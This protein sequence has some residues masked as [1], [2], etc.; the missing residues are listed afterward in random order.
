MKDRRNRTRWLSILLVC[1]VAGRTA[2][3]LVDSDK[4]P[5]EAAAWDLTRADLWRDAYDRLIVEVRTRGAVDPEALRA[6]FLGASVSGTHEREN[7]LWMIE[8]GR[9]YRRSAFAPG[10]A[11]DEVCAAPA[12][13]VS[14]R[15]ICIVPDVMSLKAGGWLMET[16]SRD[17]D[18]VDR[19]PNTGAMAFDRR[20]TARW[21]PR[22]QIASVDLSE[23]YKNAPVS[24]MA[25]FDTDLKG[26]LWQRLTNTP[27]L[28]L[29]F[30]GTSAAPVRI[31]LREPPQAGFAD[32]V[33]TGAWTSGNW[34]R[35]EGETADI[36]YTVRAAR[37]EA[38]EW[39]IDAQWASSQDRCIELAVA[40]LL[41]GAGWRWRDEG[42]R[43]I[44]L[45][46]TS[47]VT[48]LVA[49]AAGTCAAHAVCPFGVVSRGGTAWLLQANVEEPRVVRLSAEALGEHRALVLTFPLALTSATSNFVRRATVSCRLRPVPASA[50]NVFWAAAAEAMPMAAAT[51]T[52]VDREAF[53][54]LSQWPV[55]RGY[56]RL[57]LASGAVV[58]RQDFETLLGFCADISGP[59]GEAAL[60]TQLGG[61]RDPS[62]GLSLRPAQSGGDAAVD[63]NLDP[64]LRVT[65]EQP[66]SPAML[67]WREIGRL[68]QRP[69]T[70]GIIMDLPDLSR[71][72][73]NPSAIG[74][75]DYPCV[76]GEQNPRA[77]LT[78]GAGVFEFLQLAG[79]KI[80][81]QGKRLAVRISGAP[82]ASVLLL[83]DAVILAPSPAKWTVDD[84]ERTARAVRAMAGRR[85]VFVEP[86][87]W[88]AAEETDGPANYV[89]WGFAPYGGV[90][91][92]VA[93]LA[94]LLR[95][96]A[97]S[98]WNL[99][100]S[101]IWPSGDVEARVF[102]ETND[103]YHLALYNGSHRDATATRPESAGRNM[104]WVNPLTGACEYD[105][106]G[107]EIELPAGETTLWDIMPRERAA[108]EIAFLR[109]AAK[110]MA[111]APKIIQNIESW[112]RENEWGVDAR[113]VLPPAIGRPGVNHLRLRIRNGGS[114]PLRVYDVR[115]I[116]KVFWDA[117]VK[118]TVPPLSTTDVICSLDGEGMAEDGWIEVQWKLERGAANVLE[119]ARHLRLTLTE[120]VVVR[121]ESEELK[122]AGNGQ[123]M[124]RFE[125]QNNTDEEQEI[126]L[127]W[128]G[129]FKG[130]RRTVRLKAREKLPVEIA[131][132]IGA[133]RVGELYVVL[134]RADEKWRI[135]KF[136]LPKFPDIGKTD[137]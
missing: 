128:N 68:L 3:A 18:A 66:L 51:E 35:W 101:A 96:I 4:Q 137:A 38:G 109:E 57:P 118:E 52:F 55:V 56:Y 127:R 88:G 82:D 58:N 27:P 17:G 48:Q 95:R 80:R 59:E 113:A 28:L 54:S 104:L 33:F 129:D 134:E 14:N 43:S 19:I 16:V 119:C 26:T 7:A 124:A 132:R 115:I 60:A 93:A 42:G 83:A 71:L 92:D 106:P 64:D 31:M 65:K 126:A 110:T 133:A 49:A 5:V 63:W 61:A 23:L 41:E 22:V 73:Y 100:A 21:M 76:C 105:G 108:D 98:G 2:V 50:A 67:V 20:E 131:V 1:V 70:S 24:L 45:D 116:G 53:A 120:A 81:E 84:A 74:V 103:V 9:L 87:F 30:D 94:P 78:I 99:A 37:L 39:Q 77:A 123:A 125:L 62:G 112:R 72:D 79:P 15:W 32:C 40:L 46:G 114:E 121:R 11:W 10:W 29:D 130:G 90:P 47:V 107:S 44:D 25:R 135:L 122:P 8:R 6:L 36:R 136:V 91:A 75:A 13:A 34:T 111:A 97:V 85:P 117:D 69:E 89:R 86:A 12:I 102:G